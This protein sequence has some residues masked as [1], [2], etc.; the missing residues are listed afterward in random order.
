MRASRGL[1]DASGTGRRQH[2]WTGRER[3]LTKQVYDI[4]TSRLLPNRSSGARLS[5][6]ESLKIAGLFH[7]AGEAETEWMHRHWPR[8]RM[9]EFPVFGVID[10]EDQSAPLVFAQNEEVETLDFSVWFPHL[11]VIVPEQ[12]YKCPCCGYQPRDAGPGFP[13]RRKK[14]TAE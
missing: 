14:S 1:P 2:H 11:M 6:L 4:D 10:V 5:Q 7:R 3:P 12:C 13:G 9:I 8:L